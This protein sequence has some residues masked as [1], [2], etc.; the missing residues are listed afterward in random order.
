MS[1]ADPHDQPVGLL[2]GLSPT[3][4]NAVE[5]F[6]DRETLGVIDAAKPAVIAALAAR[7]RPPVLVLTATPASAADLLDALP[8]WLGREDRDRL[9]SFPARESAPYERQRP[10]PDLVEARLSTV[11][12]LRRRSPIVV[13]DIDAVAQRTVSIAS[14]PIE[15]CRGAELRLDELVRALDASGYQR[16]RIVVEPACFAVRGGIIDLWPP[17]D[18][19]PVRVELF[20]DEVE[21]MRRF[22]PMTQRST[23]SVERVGV[24]P[25]REW[26][27]DDGSGQ[28]IQDL[29]CAVDAAQS[30]ETATELNDEAAVL[31][32]DIEHLRSGTPTSR[33]DF[34][35][36]FLASSS[37]F[38]HLPKEA[39]IL[40]DEPHDLA[41]RMEDRDERARH[42]RDEL[43]RGGRVPVGLPHPWLEQDELEARLKRAPQHVRSLT[44]L[45][46]G[47]QRLPFRS[48]PRLA[49]K[50]AQL[51]ESLRAQPDSGARVMVSLQEARL[52][53]LMAD[54]GLPLATLAAEAVPLPAVISVGRAAIA[55]GWQLDDP[56]TGQRLLT[57]ISDTEI[58]G[59]ERQ[60]QR[61]PLRARGGQAADPHLLETLKPGDFVV[62]IDSGI[63]RFHGIVHERLGGR[64]GEYLDLRYSKGDRLLVPTDK[65]DRVQP[66]VGPSDAPP[67][68]TRL[69]GGQWQRAKARVRGA[70]AEIADELLEVH[71]ARETE[72]GI[73]IEPDTPWQIELEASF[74]Y[75]ETLDQHRAIE[76]VR[77]D[78]E[79]T[80]PM[81]RLVVG[82]VGYGKT[83]VAVRAAF[84]AVMS[85]HQVA[86]LVPTTVLAQQHFDTFR[87]RLAAMQVEVDLLSRLRT[88]AEQQVTLG[89]LRAG[90]VDIVIGTH[91]LLQ[92]DIAFKSLGLVVIDEEQRFGVEHKERLKKLRRE[93]DV[94]T[95]SATPI[96]RSLHQAVTGIRDM[97]TIATP[98]EERLPISTYVMERDDSVIREAILREMDRGGQVY[99]LHNEVR[100]IDSETIELRRL[101]PEARFLIAHG[102]MPANV[103]R[104]H[105]ERFISGDADVLVCST[106]IESGVDIP[107]VNTIILDRAERLGLAQMYQLRGRVGRSSVRAYAYLMTEPYRSLTEVAQRRLATIMEADD[108]GAGFQIALKDLEIRGAGNLLGAQQSG[109]IG[110]VGFTLFTQLLAEAVDRARS[111]RSGERPVSRRQGTRVNVDLALPRFLPETYVEDLG[112]RMTL[113]QRLA[114]AESPEAVEDFA[115]ELVDRFGPLPVPT[116][117][118]LG[119]VKLK[120]LASRI[121]AEAIQSEGEQVILRLAPGL[122]FSPEQRK[123]RVPRQ[124]QIGSTQLRYAPS[125]RLVEANWEEVLTGVLQQLSAT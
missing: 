28:R 58:F 83:E 33:P 5:P 75:V 107:R 60:R 8:L 98:P 120:V 42:A 104:D 72:P 19:A 76:E 51:F 30:E 29:V 64:E 121:G 21:S 90:A 25:A 97:S 9:L 48:T 52:L 4:L 80:K 71:A 109:H 67:T 36:Q 117:N 31:A 23:E 91:R 27:Q 118:L 95:L 45:G 77:Q 37:I 99:F 35:T 24:R 82:D 78:Q 85:G 63:G 125:R 16:S 61:R 49:G 2:A 38:D 65:L 111:R 44:R 88:S 69:G 39:L 15:V 13:A 86:V 110:A 3:V 50:L 32:L 114:A 56:A 62:H 7:H 54:L 108:L 89:G 6:D 112:L 55:E 122:R 12:A 124:I 22:D 96:P 68:L 81:D 26:S 41:A 43:E 18:D 116:I 103:L 66:Y 102:Q 14:A 87:Q 70:V 47:D 84:K 53:E 57:L 105:M 79:A 94:L 20:G 34:W 17:A 101:V 93:V 113:Y 106:I 119:A 123:I 100:S 73:A 59:F 46:S 74:P 92:K 11:E 40:V 115:R 1:A 10:A